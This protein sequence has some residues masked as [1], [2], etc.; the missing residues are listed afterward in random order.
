MRIR[1]LKAFFWPDA[2]V[3]FCR[4]YEG[5]Y[6]VCAYPLCNIRT[7]LGFLLVILLLTSLTVTNKAPF[8]FV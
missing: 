6:S 2:Q 5:E 3:D 1:Y 8:D 7:L 4:K